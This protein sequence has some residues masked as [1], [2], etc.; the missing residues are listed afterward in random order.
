MSDLTAEIEA[1]RREKQARYFS[2]ER[3]R[4]L[5]EDD[6]AEDARIEAEY[7]RWLARPRLADRDEFDPNGWYSGSADD[8]ERRMRDRR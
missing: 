7:Q 6:R 3:E 1:R 4:G 8:R 5:F 2:V